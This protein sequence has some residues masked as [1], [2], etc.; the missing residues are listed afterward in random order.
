MDLGIDPSAL[1]AGSHAATDNIIMFGTIAFIGFFGRLLY[2]AFGPGLASANP[3]S[4]FS[5]YGHILVAVA[6]FAGALHLSGKTVKAQ[7]LFNRHLVDPIL[8][9][10][11]GR[12][13]CDQ[14]GDDYCVIVFEQDREMSVNWYDKR[15]HMY[16]LL[17][18]A[19]LPL[20]SS[21]RPQ[22]RPRGRPTATPPAQFAGA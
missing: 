1:A 8:V 21:L 7:V 12:D 22:G 2:V 14:N 16:E 9:T 20:W 17:N 4:N 10:V 15:V 13:S 3:L 19:E 5:G 18:A 11:L 6:L